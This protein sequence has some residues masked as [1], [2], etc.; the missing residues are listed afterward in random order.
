MP[1]SMQV[2]LTCIVAGVLIAVFNRLGR[3]R[4]AGRGKR[5]KGAQQ[6]GRSWHLATVARRD[7]RAPDAAIQKRTFGPQAPK[8]IVVPWK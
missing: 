1:P 3:L 2:G 5:C 8:M 7:R 4:A 6:G